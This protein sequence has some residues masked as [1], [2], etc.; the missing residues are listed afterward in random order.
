LQVF[1]YLIASLLFIVIRVANPIPPLRT[2]A[3]TSVNGLLHTIQQEWDETVLEAFNL[4]QQLDTTRK[5]LAHSLYQYD[6]ACRVIARLIKERDEAYNMVKSF[7]G[8]P[9][10]AALTNGNHNSEEGNSAEMETEET[11][12]QQ[13]PNEISATVVEELNTLCKQLSSGRKHRKPSEFLQNKDN[14]SKIQ[15]VS[16]FSPHKGGITS[17]AVRSIDSSSSHSNDH[18]LLSAGLDK[19]LILSNLSSGQVYCK[20]NGHKDKVNVVAF[21]PSSSSTSDLIFSCSRDRTLKI[22]SP[23]SSSS[24]TNPIYKEAMSVTHS[25]SVN[26]FT[27][28]PTGNYVISATEN[29][30]WNFIDCHRGMILKSVDDNSKDSHH[31]GYS[32][33]SLHPDGLILGT[34]TI[35]GELKVWD[36][37]EQK[38]VSSLK[39]SSSESVFSVNSVS[40]SE[41]GYLTA[42]GYSNGEVKVWDL[43]KLCCMK[44][45]QSKLLVL[46]GI[47][48]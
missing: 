42:I 9:N 28:Q 2:A 8:A 12:Q 43:R 5:E 15:E 17:I 1:F 10:G 6:A 29:G 30:Q 44:T 39:E 31:S 3:P 46:C 41:N 38:L 26:G 7:Q 48:F 23:N 37:R 34:G 32:V 35:N 18:Y 27:V 4:R 20:M 45:F 36:I 25:S 21:S 24:L 13:S 40:F 19:S 16:S 22:W 14:M 11:S 33:C 47:F